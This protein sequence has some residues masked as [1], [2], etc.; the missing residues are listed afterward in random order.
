MDTRE[1]LIQSTRELLWER[2]YAAT[3]PRAILE[4]AEVGQGSMY[5]HFRGKEE[6]ALAA[7]ARNTDLM[8]EQVEVDLSEPASA[9]ERIRAYLHRERDVMRGCRVGRLTQDPEVMSSASLHDPVRDMFAW[10]VRRLTVV[11]ADGIR[12]GEFPAGLSAERT[13]AMIAA[14]LQGG[15]VLARAA[16]DTA[17][18][19]DAIDGAL[20]L[21]E[22]Q[23]KR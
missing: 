6:L 11:I 8:R 23:T 22:A 9:Y 18:F 2:G 10:L 5:H 14:V 16:N 12:D 17:V 20:D 3:S 1:R 13:A 21:L 7:M 4:S 15:Y 19:D